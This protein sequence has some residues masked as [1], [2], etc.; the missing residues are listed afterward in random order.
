MNLEL[1]LQLNT[2]TD[3]SF[4]ICSL[5]MK[6]SVSSWLCKAHYYEEARET[7]FLSKP[8]LFHLRYN[9]CVLRNTITYIVYI[10]VEYVN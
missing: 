8:N 1:S 7:L 10:D 9:D 3:L 4:Y 6:Q 5:F 2:S